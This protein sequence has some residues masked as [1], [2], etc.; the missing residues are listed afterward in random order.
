MR[1]KVIMCIQRE[2]QSIAALFNYLMS[3]MLCVNR[4]CYQGRVVLESR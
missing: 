4:D 3:A 1:L 2:T